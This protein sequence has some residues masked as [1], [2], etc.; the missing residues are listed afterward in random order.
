MNGSLRGSWWRGRRLRRIAI[1]AAMLGISVAARADRAEA[2]VGDVS[3][4]TTLPTGTYIHS[5]L[6]SDDGS[7]AVVVASAPNDG[8]T[9]SVYVVNLA[10]RATHTL[11]WS[12]YQYPW[13]LS[14]DGSRLLFSRADDFGGRV[15]VVMD[16]VTGVV[17]YES[18]AGTKID[19][20]D[21]SGDGTT[22]AMTVRADMLRIQ[23]ADVAAGTLTAITPTANGHSFDVKVSD[24]GA[25]VAFSTYSTDLLGGYGPAAWNRSTGLVT[26]AFSTTDG[27]SLVDGARNIQLSGNGRYVAF[28]SYGPNLAGAHGTASTA[29]RFDRDTGTTAIVAVG[30]DGFPLESVPTDISTDGRSVLLGGPP[31]QAE[32]QPSSHLGVAGYQ[33]YA[34]DME[35]GSIQLASSMASGEPAYGQTQQAQMDG[36]G[37]LVGFL[38]SS[39]NMGASDT[40]FQPILKEMPGSTLGVGA[41]YVQGTPD[42]P[43]IGGWF[44]G[45]VTVHWQPKLRSGGSAT[46]PAPTT[47][48]AEGLNMA[49][50]APSCDGAQCSTG[51]VAIAIDTTPPTWSLPAVQDGAGRI[52]AVLFDSGSGIDEQ[53]LVV[54]GCALSG[55]RCD[56]GLTSDTTGVWILRGFGGPFGGEVSTIVGT[57]RV[58]HPLVA[59]TPPG[60]PTSVTLA[61][62]NGGTAVHFVAPP[63]GGSPIASYSSWCSS[64]N[65]GAAGSSSG[66]SSPVTVTGLTAGKSYTCSVHA[67]NGAGSGPASDPSPALVLP[68]RPTA[69][70][71]ISAV[72]S[73]SLRVSVGFDPP[74]SYGA[75]LIAKYTASCVSSTGA[76][77]RSGSGRVSPVVLGGLTAGATYTC[78]VRAVNSSGTGPASLPSMPVTVPDTP[79]PPTGVTATM[80]PTV[81]Q[82]SVTFGPPASDGGAAVAGYQ[83]SCVS[84]NGGVTRPAS[85]AV[86]PI[87]VISLTKGATYT[88]TVRASNISGWGLWSAS[89]PSLTVPRAPDAPTITS[90]SSTTA[91][92]LTVGANAPAFDG[93]SPI[94]GYRATCNSSTGG[95][96]RSAAS[97][98]TS[99]TVLNMTRGAT[100]TCV[101]VA[102]NGYG[103]G[104]GSSPS[105]SIVVL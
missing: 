72:V 74:A 3:V 55:S 11:P 73:G 38:T 102:S 82:A 87:V 56:Y 34:V 46:V 25:V 93:G 92:R 32:G 104:I 54:N 10:T 19:E 71:V 105:A 41:P 103:T 81:R 99:I 91:R 43:A 27:G 76:A 47:V 9:R 50:S 49:T 31:S 14:D 45:P 35:L 33:A 59:A 18:P 86:S 69:P 95:T 79:G 20:A 58:G 16:T 52:V 12:S 68:I 78:T 48:S 7:T 90:V 94:I 30:W 4:T 61:P 42:R 80:T 83:V 29:F 65:G 75:S 88:C 1:S 60:A 96:T 89:S 77:T 17:D 57:D 22:V 84:S 66:P 8:A 28:S 6:L 100:Y 67:T 62:A 23:A 39:V 97:P 70:T 21:L 26:R 44:A 51:R 15:A 24:D 37:Q 101:V 64:S 40:T 53:S 63:D 98:T 13:A 36:N 5:Q 2:A 85:G